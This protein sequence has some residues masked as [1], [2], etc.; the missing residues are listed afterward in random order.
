M[1]VDDDPAMRAALT[2]ILNWLGYA[3]TEA[4][5]AEQAV[6]SLE[7][8]AS[9]IAAVVCDVVMPGMGGE[10]LTRS[11]AARWP[12]IPVILVSGYPSPSQ[13][14]HPDQNVSGSGAIVRLQKPFSCRQMAQALSTALH[15]T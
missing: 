5:S 1:V 3:A 13:T 6:S 12:A 10:T 8:Q 11:I 4:A 14:A 2:N 7:D 15:D 9:S